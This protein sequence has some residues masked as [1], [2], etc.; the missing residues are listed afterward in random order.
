MEADLDEE[1]EIERKLREF[2]LRSTDFRK[3]DAEAHS[4][5]HSEPRYY[6]PNA[7][8]AIGEKMI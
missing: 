3:I 6:N 8:E 1:W 4:L 2:R 7:N 5:Y